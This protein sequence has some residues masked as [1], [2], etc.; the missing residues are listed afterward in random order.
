[1]GVDLGART[2]CHAISFKRFKWLYIIFVACNNFVNLRMLL[3]NAV[4]IY[5]YIY[6]YIYTYISY[7]STTIM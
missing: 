4:Y 5:I 3:K 2:C 1:M 7:L 6:I